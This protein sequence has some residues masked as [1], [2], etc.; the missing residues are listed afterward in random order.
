MSYEIG[1]YWSLDL[2]ELFFKKLYEKYLKT[3]Y[4]EEENEN[5]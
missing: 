3:V 2:T 5:T 4:P 1:G